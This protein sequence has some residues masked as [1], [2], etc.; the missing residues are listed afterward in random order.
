MSQKRDFTKQI[1]FICPPKY[2]YDY[3]KTLLLSATSICKTYEFLVD[4]LLDFCIGELDFSEEF[5]ASNVWKTI[6]N[7]LDDTKLPHFYLTAKKM[8]PKYNVKLSQYDMK[9]SHHMLNFKTTPKNTLKRSECHEIISKFSPKTSFNS[10]Y[11]TFK[12]EY[13]E[14]IWLW[15]TGGTQGEY[16][17]GDY[18]SYYSFCGTLN[19]RK[20]KGKNSD[21][22]IYVKVEIQHYTDGYNPTGHYNLLFYFSDSLEIF[23]TDSVSDW[24]WFRSSQMKQFDPNV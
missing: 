1:P 6:Q 3:Y 2:H 23:W 12:K 14:S 19:H 21:R 4:I 8:N 11:D 24:Q 22:K 13:F 9:Q 16:G 17:D 20:F 18:S 5:F 15:N 7:V 10:F